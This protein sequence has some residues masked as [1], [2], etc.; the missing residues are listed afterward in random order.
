MELTINISK[1]K[2]NFFE[3][4][5]ISGLITILVFILLV[6]VGILSLITI[7]PYEFI[8]HKI[9]R[10]ERRPY[11]PPKPSTL[12]KTEKYHLTLEH[13]EQPNY[14]HKVASDFLYTIVNYGDESA[15]FL[16]INNGQKTDLDGKYL[17]AFKYLLDGSMLL[18]KVR[19]DENGKPTSD[20]I[21][22]NI[23]NGTVNTLEEIG[24][25]ELNKFNEDK[26]EIV[27]F[28][29]TEN[30]CIKLKSKN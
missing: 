8:K 23:S 16:V 3:S 11:A 24:T 9:L 15:V 14:I 25:F 28:N 1:R 26:N 10:Y 17:T 13:I 21:K 30:I 29:L 4:S 6:V 27:G 20:L 2:K 7:V 12:M 22:F 19:V 5:I 18:Q